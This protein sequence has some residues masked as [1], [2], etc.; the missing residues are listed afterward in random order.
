MTERLPATPDA[1]RRAAALLHAG[2]TVVFPTETVYGLGAHALRP[3]GIAAV[4]AAKERPADDPLIV[5]VSPAML[6][7]RPSQG[8]VDLGLAALD[9]ALAALVDRLAAAFWPGPLTLLL[10][11]GAAVLDAVTAGLGEVAIR[12]P[13]HPVALALLDA[14]G[15]PLVA[16]S[17]NRFGRISPTTAEAALAELN[18]RVPLILDGGP[19]AIGV[20]STVLRPRPAQ[21]LRPGA[22][23]PDALAAT[24]GVAPALTDR[25]AGPQPSPGLSERHYAPRTPLRPWTN[26]AGARPSGLADAARVGVLVW[27]ADSQ[28]RAI[29]ELGTRLTA[30]EVL[31]PD[32]RPATAAQR[33]YG[34]LRR[35]DEAGCDVLLAE[36]IPGDDGLSLALRDRLRRASAP[37]RP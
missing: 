9:P 5:H 1:L 31:A 17:A 26:H 29:R 2:Q 27:S 22:V 3:D 34:A 28:L 7:A 20:E 12:V 15:A 4:F 16:P 25:G 36:P 6:G 11:R 35:L 21:V 37:E 10:P 24:L 18:G 33:L 8:L 32:G 19:C 14:A 13:V 23:T 30:I